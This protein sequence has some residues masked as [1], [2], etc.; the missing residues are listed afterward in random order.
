MSKVL[1]DCTDM[2][3]RMEAL[4]NW[5]SKLP[6]QEK[7]L[8][9][10]LQMRVALMKQFKG[11][12][13]Q[14]VD[15]FTISQQQ[16][17][18]AIAYIKKWFAAM[19]SHLPKPNQASAAARNAAQPHASQP[20]PN[21]QPQPAIPP[22]NASNLQQL[23]RQQEEALQRARRVQNHAAPPAP[24]TLQP[25]FPLGAP[26]PQG[27]PHAYGPPGLTKDKLVIPPAK[28]RKQNP[29]A[30]TSATSTP[31]A[32]ASTPQ[33]QKQTPAA[34]TNK[35]TP[36][37]SNSFRC[38]VS[39][40][41]HHIRG[42]ATQVALDTHINELHKVE[43][44]VENALE[45]VLESYRTALAIDKQE[46][47]TQEAAEDESKRKNAPEPELQ[48]PPQP[49]K[50]SSTPKLNSEHMTPGTTPAGRSV[51]Q[52]GMK[53]SPSSNNAK[54]SQGPAA[55]G[56]GTAG[57]NAKE[58]QS[59]ESKKD[60]GKNGE[61]ES[62]PEDMV[63][64][65]DPWAESAISIETIRSG[66]SDWGSFP[67]L[68]SDPLEEV[69]ISDVFT[70]IR[71]KDTPQS[72]DTSA[73]THT[74]KDTDSSRDDE[75]DVNMSGSNDDSWIPSDWVNLP[76]QLE[77]GLLMNEPWEEVNWDALEENEYDLNG[78]NLVQVVYSI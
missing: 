67:G 34:E 18:S 20:P 53:P 28:R 49:S 37:V 6:N 48:R 64:V 54:L 26:S 9:V 11:P 22:L 52:A 75:V 30:K 41:E 56:N 29:A 46:K 42:F 13:W 59:K 72:T 61:Q 3:G 12:D 5:V 43:E 38:P 73:N 1:T 57:S 2:L 50:P 58:Q 25:P 15:Q 69:L 63:F 4:V 32:P 44:P 10:L 27:V 24:T 21:A 66:F 16:L 65:K 70:N 19:I 76:G 35:P 60:N 47:K 40:C 39:E 36:P 55:T 62:S 17:V 74:P 14:L 23:E 45:F 71:E 77:G 31:A 51:S 78:N 8:Q 7:T 68:E 33:G